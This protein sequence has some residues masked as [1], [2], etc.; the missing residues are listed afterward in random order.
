MAWPTQIPQN[1]KFAKSLQYLKKVRDEVDFCA[2]S[3]TIFYKLILSFLQG[4]A[5][6]A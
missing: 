5:R 2:V 4:V 3:I 1:D 6:H